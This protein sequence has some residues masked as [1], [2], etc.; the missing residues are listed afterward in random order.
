MNNVVGNWARNNQMN[1]MALDANTGYF[2]SYSFSTKIQGEC[3]RHRPAVLF[4]KAKEKRKADSERMLGSNGL[5]IWQAVR[6]KHA[7]AIWILGFPWYHL[8]FSML[9][10][11][12]YVPQVPSRN[13]WF[14]QQHPCSIYSY[15]QKSLPTIVHKQE[16]W[17]SLF[18][19]AYTVKGN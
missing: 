6:R 13:A 2:Q 15:V 5:F 8:R 16:S 3:K 7:G 12:S 14:A 4:S 17:Q 10:K 18:L 11:K 19:I 9:N 1:P